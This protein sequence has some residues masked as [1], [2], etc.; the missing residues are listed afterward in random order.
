[1][2]VWPK[3]RACTSRGS[4]VANFHV[5][6]KQHDFKTY[7]TQLLYPTKFNISKVTFNIF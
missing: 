4:Y 3:L 1:M 7:Q 6:D 2:C 5:L